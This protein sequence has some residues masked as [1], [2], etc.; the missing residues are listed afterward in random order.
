LFHEV[1]PQQAKQCGVTK[2]KRGRRGKRV[3]GGNIAQENAWP[4]LVNMIDKNDCKQYCSGVVIDE[5]WVLT[6]AHCFIF[7]GSNNS[8]TILPF[9]NYTYIIGDHKYNHTD[10]HEYAVE[11]AQLFV[12]PKYKLADD[13]Q[14]GMLSYSSKKLIMCKECGPY[15]VCFTD[16]SENPNVDTKYFGKY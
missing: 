6:A 11:P 15:F 9:T 2:D 5:Q 12:H 13:S 16:M 7:S 10:S 8:A 4:W 14:P 1:F 3:I